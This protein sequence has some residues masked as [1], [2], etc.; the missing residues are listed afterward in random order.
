MP[1]DLQTMPVFLLNFLELNLLFSVD[2]AI[3]LLNDLS[4]SN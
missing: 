3:V 2:L 1:I 4:K